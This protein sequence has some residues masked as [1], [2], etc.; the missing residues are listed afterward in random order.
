[1]SILFRITLI[2]VGVLL[3]AIG[4][5]MSTKQII[6]P[7]FGPTLILVGV[8]LIT[9]GACDLWEAIRSMRPQY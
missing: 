6:G 8:I 4:A 5:R 3:I 9:I 1:M 7:I 2:A